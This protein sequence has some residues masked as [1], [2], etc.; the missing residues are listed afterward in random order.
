[1]CVRVSLSWQWVFL[2]T[3]YVCAVVLHENLNMEEII[4]LILIT[5]CQE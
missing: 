4:D 5:L 3:G 2:K 1:M